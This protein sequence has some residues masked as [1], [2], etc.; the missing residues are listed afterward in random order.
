VIVGDLDVSNL[1]VEFKVLSTLKP[2]P[3]KC[4]LTIWNLSQ[5]HRAELL[6]RNRPNASSSKLVGIPVQVEAGYKDNTSVIFS[7]D[8]REVASFRDDT[9]WKTT[10]SG[11]DGG[12]SYREARF[13]PGMQY[14]AGARI[15]DILKKCADAMGIGLGNAANFEATAQIAGIGSVL[16]H[17]FTLDGS[18]SKALTR[19]LNSIGLTWSIQRGALQLLQ[20]G[21]PLN[22]SAIRLTPSTGLLDSPEAA[23]DATVSLGNPQQ[24]A[25]GAKQT[26]KKVK[27]K[28]P[29]I[30]KLKAMLIPGLDPG[31]KIA[32]ESANFN[33]GYYLTECE[34]VGQS[35]ADDWHVNA[36]AR[37]YT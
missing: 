8:L 32:L 28:D 30:L 1:D 23:I 18:A 10:L 4:V 11:D 24:F 15:G 36:V 26:T 7:G 19:L 3:N 33:G 17:S 37:Q 27:P 22:Q 20:K 35:W 9:D 29:G 16:A 13:S 14:N 12:R 34:K 21:A 31:R 6:K 2:E 5:D 25:P